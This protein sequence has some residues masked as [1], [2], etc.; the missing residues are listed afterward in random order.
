[1]VL[2]EKFR[3][4]GSLGSFGISPFIFQLPVDVLY[5]QED[6]SYVQTIQYL[7]LGYDIIVIFTGI[8]NTV[9]WI[10]FLVWVG[11]RLIEVC[12]NS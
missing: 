1:M 11:T 3:S 5:Q 10:S 6:F 7:W 12:E 2:N 4:D 8:L 9:I